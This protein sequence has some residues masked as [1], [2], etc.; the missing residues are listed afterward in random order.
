[1]QNQSSASL[2]RFMTKRRIVVPR[3]IYSIR[4]W[5]YRPRW[6]LR[7]S[8]RDD[9][10]TD[11]DAYRISVKAYDDRCLQSLEL[12]LSG[13]VVMRENYTFPSCAGSTTGRDHSF[14]IDVPSDAPHGENVL[15]SLVA[16][17][18]AGQLSNVDGARVL[19]DTLGPTIE[20]ISQSRT[21]S[22]SGNH[23]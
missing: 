8:T 16:T 4:S 5:I 19:R 7:T 20:I 11:F 12:A 3:R 22:L 23:G 9:L 14:Y 17:D 15:M 6:S 21:S 18:S 10:P 2:R 1:M 13:G